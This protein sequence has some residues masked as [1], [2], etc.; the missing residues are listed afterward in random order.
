[1]EALPRWQH[2]KRGLI[3]PVQFVPIAEESGL[4]VPI[5]QWVLLQACR[6]SRVRMDVGIPPVRIA[7]K[8]SA[9]EFMAKDFLSGV[10]ATPNFD[11]RGPSQFRTGAN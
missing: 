10:R 4:I 2:P 5:G 8:V 11:W 6:Q 7:I 9:A 1:V 3:S